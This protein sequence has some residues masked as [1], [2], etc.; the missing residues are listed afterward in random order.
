MSRSI[1][2]GILSLFVPVSLLE[3]NDLREVPLCACD[4][5]EKASALLRRR[6]PR[7]NQI[8]TFAMVDNNGSSAKK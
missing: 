6:N 7:A 1:T 8:R 5:V 4:T 2:N 3:N